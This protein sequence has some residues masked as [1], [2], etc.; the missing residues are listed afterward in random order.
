MVSAGVGSATSA[1][2]E[3]HA[4]AAPHAIDV[5]YLADKVYALLLAD[6]RLGRA[7]ADVFNAPRRNGRAD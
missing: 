7:R 5:Q 3:N 1:G 6:V 2:G 4:G